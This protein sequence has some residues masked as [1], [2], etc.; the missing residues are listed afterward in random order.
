M[1]SW[2]LH[3]NVKSKQKG[4]SGE[5]EQWSLLQVK[6]DSSTTSCALR[7]FS[8]VFIS[9]SNARFQIQPSVVLL[10]CGRRSLSFESQFWTLLGTSAGLGEFAV[11]SI[12]GGCLPRLSSDVLSLGRAYAGKMRRLKSRWAERRKRIVA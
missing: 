11:G 5:W 8:K 10:G 3:A 6:P 12:G 4:L 1:K 7:W 2:R 9:M